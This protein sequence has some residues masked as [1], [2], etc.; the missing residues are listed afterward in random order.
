[1]HMDPPSASK[2]ATALLEGSLHLPSRLAYSPWFPIF[3]YKTIF[4]KIS[5]EAGHNSNMIYLNT[6]YET[7]EILS[8]NTV[9]LSL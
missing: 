6:V 5:K 9:M 1:M 2:M 3:N 7:L 4:L 8:C